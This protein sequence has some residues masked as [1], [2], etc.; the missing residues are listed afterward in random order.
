MAEVDCRLMLTRVSEET[1]RQFIDIKTEIKQVEAAI[2]EAMNNGVM[3]WDQPR[4]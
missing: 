2:I 1:N 3:K 4:P